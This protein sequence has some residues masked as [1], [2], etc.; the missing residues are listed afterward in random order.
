MSPSVH[1]TRANELDSATGQTDGMMRQGAITGKSNKMCSLGKPIIAEC[2]DWMG[3]G[4][5]WAD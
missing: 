2:L 4:G 5:Q 1:V 3:E